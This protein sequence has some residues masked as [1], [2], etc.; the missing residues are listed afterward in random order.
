MDIAARRLASL[1][2]IPAGW[3]FSVLALAAVG[4]LWTLWQIADDGNTVKWQ[5]GLGRQVCESLLDRAARAREAARFYVEIDRD[6]VRLVRKP[7]RATLHYRRSPGDERP[8]RPTA[9]S[10]ASARRSAS[11]S[12]PGLQGE[13][14]MDYAAWSQPWL[15]RTAIQSA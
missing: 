1:R 14:P 4:P 9:A 15:I 8:E 13:S 6:I 2:R 10:L 11:S 7:V 5:T 12:F 3:L